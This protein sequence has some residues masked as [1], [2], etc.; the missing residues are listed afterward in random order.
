MWSPVFSDFCDYSP[1]SGA[2]EAAGEI[3]EAL[4][5]SATT[6]TNAMKTATEWARNYS[7]I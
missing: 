4:E 7:V 6:V 1:G 5:I 3:S 2:R